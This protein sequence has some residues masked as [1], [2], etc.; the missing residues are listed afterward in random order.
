METFNRDSGKYAKPTQ[1]VFSGAGNGAASDIGDVP[2]ASET[3]NN[4]FISN[5][6]GERVDLPIPE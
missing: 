3:Q 5:G 2:V 1:A 4:N 6:E